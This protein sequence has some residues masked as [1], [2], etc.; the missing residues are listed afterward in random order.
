MIASESSP[1][2]VKVVDCSGEVKDKYFISNLLKDVIDEVG[3]QKV[4]Q[5]ITDNA[6]NC[7]G[8][9]EIIEGMFPHIYWTPCVCAYS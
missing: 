2:F 3:H 5:I 7:K 6:K 8:A 9:G 4:V 1:M